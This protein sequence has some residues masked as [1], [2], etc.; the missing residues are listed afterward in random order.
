MQF[1]KNIQKG[2]VNLGRIDHCYFVSCLIPY[3]HLTK[4]LEQK[5]DEKN[6]ITSLLCVLL[7]LKTKMATIIA[8]G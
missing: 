2:A 5:F 8:P 7:P 1:S 3:D 4:K 6:G